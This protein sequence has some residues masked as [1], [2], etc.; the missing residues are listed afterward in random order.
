M[1]YT[2]SKIEVFSQSAAELD[3]SEEAAAGYREWLTAQLRAEFLAADVDVYD[4]QDTRI[5]HIQCSD[6]SDNYYTE[7][8]D[9]V[10]IFL[11]ECFER[12]PWD[13]AV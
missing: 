9:E 7:P 3:C 13:W 11:I 12:C 5:V 6:D 10:E 2:I 1:T 8:R 4:R